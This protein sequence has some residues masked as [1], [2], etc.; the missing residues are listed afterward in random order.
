MLISLEKQVFSLLVIKKRTRIKR[1]VFSEKL[2]LCYHCLKDAFVALE[3]MT[4]AYAGAR[5]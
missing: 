5:Q 4:L 2:V 1:Y 3:L